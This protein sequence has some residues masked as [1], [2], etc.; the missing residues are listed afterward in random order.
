MPVLYHYTSQL[1]LPLILRSGFLK[2]TE[3]NV[4]M[5]R[6][7]AGPDVVWLTRDPSPWQAWM[8]MPGRLLPVDKGRIRFLVDVPHG[9]LQSWSTWADQ[10]GVAD[11]WRRAMVDSGGPS[12]AW[13]VTERIVPWQEWLRIEDTNSGQVWWR[14]TPDQLASRQMNLGLDTLHVT[15]RPRITMH[16]PAADRARWR[17]FAVARH[18]IDTLGEKEFEITQDAYD[19]LQAE[20]LPGESD[21]DLLRRVLDGA[22]EQL[23]LA[24]ANATE[25]RGEAPT[26]G[27]RPSLA[28]KLD[29]D[30]VSDYRAAQPLIEQGVPSWDARVLDKITDGMAA[31]DFTRRMRQG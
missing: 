10:H 20:R 8:R 9:E 24:R 4:A 31:E 26:L 3:S 30:I 5:E 17:D 27:I 15:N 7:H 11:A 16:V 14:Q 22:E 25:W 21:D 23:R 2:L 18:G 28:T 12:D 29:Q 19:L 1:H 13:Y 6:P